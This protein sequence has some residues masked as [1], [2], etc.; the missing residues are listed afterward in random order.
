MG[1]SSSAKLGSIYLFAFSTIY[2]IKCII[3][4]S[5]IIFSRI[6]VLL[7]IKSAKCVRT[8]CLM[9]MLVGIHVLAFALG[10]STTLFLS[11]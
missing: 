7:N 4:N 2:H 8:I 6:E 11:H 9:V 5:L 10:P 3:Y 1:S